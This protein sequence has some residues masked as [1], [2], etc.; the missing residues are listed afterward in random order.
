MKTIGDIILYP[1]LL[2]VMYLVWP[3]WLW[4][5]HGVG[6]ELKVL[7]SAIGLVLAP[8]ANG[9]LIVFIIVLL[10]L[11]LLGIIL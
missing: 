4:D 7:L 1:I 8:I 3:S 9:F 11:Q 6:I 10:W 2:L 5:T